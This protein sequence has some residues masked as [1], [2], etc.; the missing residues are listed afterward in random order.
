M[1]RA[2]QQL[3]KYR[4]EC[5]LDEG[6][7]A[8]VFRAMDTIEGTR[9]ALKVPHAHL[10]NESLLNDFRHEVRLAAKMDHPNILPL[11]NAST[12]EGHFVVAFALG[13]R[14]LD[15]R[16]ANRMSV[17]TALDFAQQMLAGVA[18]AHA[19]RIIH[20]DIKPGNM[21][22]F[23]DQ[24]LRLTDFGIARVALR[25]VR[26]SGSGT[27]GY[28]APEQAMGRLSFRSDVFSLGLILYR[29][30]TGH[31]PEWPYDWPPAGFQRLRNKVHAELIQL[32]QRAIEPDPKK[33]F[34]D[35][36]QMLSAF[37]RAKPKTLR[38][39]QAKRKP[40]EKRTTRDWREIRYHQFQRQFGSQLATH[41][42]CRQCR[43]PVSETMHACP[44]CGRKRHVAEG[45]TTFPLQCRRCRRGMK[46]DW[47]YCPWCFGP[48]YEPYQQ[49]KY[50]DRRYQARCE[51][52]RCPRG[53][54]MP[55]MKYCPWCRQ[56]V[57]RKWKIPGC[58]DRCQR[59]SWGFLKSFWT[60]CP[61]CGKRGTAP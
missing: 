31:L 39:L 4:I 46:L 50:R 14:T 3:G 47:S 42:R 26:A 40:A 56:K 13:D 41:D 21:I 35:A 34:T 29:M 60:Y 6:G 22:L 36:G 61:W 43:G 55:Y 18:Y 57:Q 54:L 33:R 52:A 27:M 11:R 49:R 8:A 9:V 45:K 37:L 44:W 16:M 17:E 2:R 24:R 30:F 7:F 1:F 38:D 12:I 58:K 48:G 5:K 53:D 10:V 19:H 23:A 51:N 28:M 15:D 32:I 20:C 59:C 25:T